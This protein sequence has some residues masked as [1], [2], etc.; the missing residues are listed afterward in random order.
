MNINVERMK[1][2]IMGGEESVEM[3]VEDIKLEQVKSFKYLGVQIQNN[4][5]QEAETN[6]R[7]STAM[8]LYYTLNR[9][10][11]KMREIIKN[12]K[13]NVHKAIF[14]PIFTYGRES[15]VLTKDIKSRIR[16]AEM[17]YL[18]RIKEITRRD[19]VRDE[20]MKEE[21][22]IEPILKRMHKQQVKWF[23]H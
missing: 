13:V 21:L 15:W 8:K 14:C 7:I 23:C 2:M 4:G 5:K 19:R 3:E 11:L 6:K 22:K 16:A 10:F 12:A 18:P 17:K 1:I 20:V 9:N